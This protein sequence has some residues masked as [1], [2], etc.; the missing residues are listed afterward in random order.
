MISGGLSDRFG[1]KRLLILAAFLFTVTS[2]G[3]GM[4]N[5]LT[6]LVVWR[7][8]GGV[9]IGL[10]SNLSP[11]Y[12]AEVAPS[13]IRGRLVSVNQ[14]TIVIGSLLAQ[15]VNW[16]VAAQER[17]PQRAMTPQAVLA[18]AENLKSHARDF[19][20]RKPERQIREARAADLQAIEARGHIL[21]ERFP[22]LDLSDK[23]ARQRG[24]A[25]IR[26]FYE[27]SPASSDSPDAPKNAVDDTEIARR[28]GGMVGDLRFVER[29]DGLAVD[30][31]PDGRPLAALSCS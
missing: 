18:K 30:V 14:L 12:I 20:A 9:A 5:T 25:R 21:Q 26:L 28:Q 22:K 19:E 11:M 24:G 3:T 4:A 10:A 8:A 2:I 1:R 7:I 31:R 13:A 16:Q 6:T 15:I 29:A 17:F 27:T 23:E